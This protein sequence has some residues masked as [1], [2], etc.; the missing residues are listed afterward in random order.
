MAGEH[1]ASMANRQ[2]EDTRKAKKQKR[3]MPLKLLAFFSPCIFRTDGYVDSAPAVFPGSPQ[4]KSNLGE[5][6]EP[7]LQKAALGGTTSID[8]SSSNESGTTNNE[9]P[10]AIELASKKPTEAVVPFEPGRCWS[11]GL[12]TAGDSSSMTV[13]MGNNDQSSSPVVGSAATTMLAADVATSAGLGQ[14]YGSIPANK[15]VTAAIDLLSTIPMRGDASG[16]ELNPRDPSAR[17]AYTHTVDRFMSTFRTIENYIHC[18]GA[19]THA[20]QVKDQVDSQRKAAHAAGGLIQTQLAF[21]QTAIKTCGQ[22][23]FTYNGTVIDDV[24][25]HQEYHDDKLRGLRM[26]SSLNS[27]SARRPKLWRRF[28]DSGREDYIVA[29]DQRS[30]RAWKQLAE[31]ALAVVDQNLN[32][33]EISSDILWS[34]IPNPQTSGTK[35]VN[36][37]KQD[38]VD[39]YKVYLYVMGGLFLEPDRIGGVLLAER[40]SSGFQVYKE[41]IPECYDEDTLRVSETSREAVLGV[42]KIYTYPCYQRRGL[43]IN[44]LDTACDHFVWEQPLGRGQVAWTQTTL[45]GHDLAEFYNTFEGPVDPRDQYCFLTYTEQA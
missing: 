27:V 28:D 35:A 32:S 25:S 9:H 43:A 20:E 44:L 41:E 3:S 37:V 45:Q 8:E 14:A 29:V 5:D 31:S 36:N 21:G 15:K 13:D 10:G 30:H 2:N 23:Q 11:H 26:E 17:A 6:S 40:I 7:G 1:D 42:N 4:E 16:R 34:S 22:C 18:E 19:S 38:L 39:K 24:K 33:K 12:S